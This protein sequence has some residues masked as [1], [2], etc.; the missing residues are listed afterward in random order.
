MEGKSIP[1]IKEDV[2]KLKSMGLITVT[3]SSVTP[4]EK[5]PR[6]QT[7]RL[8]TDQSVQIAAKALAESQITHGLVYVEPRM[9]AS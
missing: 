7:A 6:H 8:Q 2:E 5:E 1:E 3:V 4:G 9:I